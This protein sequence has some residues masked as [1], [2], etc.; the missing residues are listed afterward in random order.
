VATVAELLG[1]LAEYRTARQRLLRLLDVSVSNRDPLSE[2]SEHLVA[3]ITGGT[4]PVNRN[5]P[6]WDVLQPDGTTVQV[7]YLANV[8]TGSWV[9]WHPV[10]RIEGV[11]WYAVVVIEDFSVVGVVMFPIDQ[12]GPIGATLGKRGKQPLVDGWDLTRTSWQQIR[13]HPDT[14]RGLGVQV[15]LPPDFTWDG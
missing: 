5:Q 2:F 13:D 6:G 8:S 12:L 11:D 7:K 4:L 14:F 15:F 9:N 1:G 10:R 3:A